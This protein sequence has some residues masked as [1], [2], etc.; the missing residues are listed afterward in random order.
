MLLLAYVE[1]S[2]GLIS[3]CYN[4][5]YVIKQSRQLHIWNHRGRQESIGIA[6]GRVLILDSLQQSSRHCFLVDYSQREEVTA[7]TGQT[8]TVLHEIFALTEE[9]IA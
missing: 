2:G 9:V 7:M 1:C 4:V 6:L 3:L 5:L 8:D